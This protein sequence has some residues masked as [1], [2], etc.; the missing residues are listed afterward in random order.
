[1]KRYFIEEKIKPGGFISVTSIVEGS[2]EADQAE[3]RLW[4]SVLIQ[5]FTDIQ[6]KW[7]TDLDKHQAA[8]F[9]CRPSGDLNRLCSLAMVDIEKVMRAA[10]EMCATRNLVQRLNGDAYARQGREAGN[11]RRKYRFNG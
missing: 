5:A 4:R 1:M 10:R 11:Q 9:L 3:V 7:G 8:T 2:N 6:T